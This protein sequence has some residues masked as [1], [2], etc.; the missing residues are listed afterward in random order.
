MRWLLALVT[1]SLLLTVVTVALLARLNPPISA[2]MLAER[3]AMWLDHEPW[4]PL[5]QR[6]VDY[7]QISPAMRLAVVAGEDQTFPTHDG[8]DLES[9]RAAISDWRD[10]GRLRGASTI[11]QQLARNL[12]LWRGRSYIRK[13]LEV[14]F[15]LLLE[16]LWSKQRILEVYLNVAEMGH[17]IYGAQAAAREHFGKAASALDTREAALLAAVLPSPRKRDAGR[18]SARVRQRADWIRGQMRNLGS[19]YLD[20]L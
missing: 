18:P 16:A 19:G 12:F 15:T 20:G 8:F 6:W 7:E 1:G 13:G 4:T 9:L 2:F 17:G 10:G 11:S 5:R 14:W 3:V